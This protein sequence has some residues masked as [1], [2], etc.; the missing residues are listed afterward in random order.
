M[1]E[2]GKGKSST[3]LDEN[4]AAGLAALIWIVG[5]I[6]FFIEKDSKFVKFYG[7]QMLILGLLGGLGIIPIVGW[8]LSILILI[9]VIIN[10]IN[11]FQGKIFKVPVIGNFAAKQAGL[12]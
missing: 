10:T 2:M 5:V 6:F 9:F 3:G 4:V 12:E 8:I 1:D 11:A 7:F